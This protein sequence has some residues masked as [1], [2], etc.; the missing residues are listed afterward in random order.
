MQRSRTRLRHRSGLCQD[1]VLAQITAVSLQRRR[2]A[3]GCRSGLFGLSPSGTTCRPGTLAGVVSLFASACLIAT[4][5]RQLVPGFSPASRH[6]AASRRTSQTPHHR[7]LHRNRPA[8]A[9]DRSAFA[10]TVVAS[11]RSRAD[12]DARLHAACFR[13]RSVSRTSPLQNLPAHTQHF[14]P[15]S[16]SAAHFPRQR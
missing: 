10:H 7:P 9:P 5:R 16:T 6:R 15:N 11:S 4:V 12:Q 2:R 3:R 8:S 1:D 14:L 13:V